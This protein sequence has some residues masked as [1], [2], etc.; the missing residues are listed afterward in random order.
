MFLFPSKGIICRVPFSAL[1]RLTTGRPPALERVKPQCQC[2]TLTTSWIKRGKRFWVSIFAKPSFTAGS[3][4]TRGRSPGTGCTHSMERGVVR[5]FL[6]W[7]VT[8]KFSSKTG[9]DMTRCSDITTNGTFLSERLRG[10]VG[11]RLEEWVAIFVWSGCL[12]LGSATPRVFLAG[13]HS[14]LHKNPRTCTDVQSLGS[15]MIPKLAQLQRRLRA[16]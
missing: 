1:V 8:R 2:I 16:P 10:Q 13:A 15:L 11:Q 7:D 5:L 6:H 9:R 3:A 4:G 12:P 14:A